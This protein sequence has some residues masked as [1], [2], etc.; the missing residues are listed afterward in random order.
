MV[1]STHFS[2]SDLWPPRSNFPYNGQNLTFFFLFFFR[3][4]I[5]I[6]QESIE[7][8]SPNFICSFNGQFYT[9]FIFWPLTS[10]VKFTLWRSKLDLFFFFFFFKGTI[11]IS[12][13]PLKISS[14]NFICSLK[15]QFYT[16]FIFWPLTFKVKFP[17]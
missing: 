15:G 17:L 6:T 14:P 4:T 13:E 10:K 16:Y 1:N 8:S 11:E 2:F 12:Q 9:Y 7:I 3:G 5:E